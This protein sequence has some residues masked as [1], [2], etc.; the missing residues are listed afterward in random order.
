MC[1]SRAC[2]YGPDENKVWQFDLPEGSWIQL[3]IEK[4]DV[5]PCCDA[6]MAVYGEVP[7]GGGSGTTTWTDTSGVVRTYE[8]NQGV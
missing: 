6:F 7:G 5:E 4:V 1:V 8:P 2:S 3:R